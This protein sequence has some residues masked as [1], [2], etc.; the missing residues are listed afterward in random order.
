MSYLLSRSRRRWSLLG[1]VTVR[2]GPLPIPN[3]REVLA[4]LIDVMLVLDEFVLH[5]LFK[6]GAPGTQVWQAID[7]VLHEM[8]AV[9]VILHPHVEGGG[10]GALFLVAADVQVAVGSA[11]GQPVNEP[12]VTMK[13]KDDVLVAREERIVIRFAQS[14]RVLAGRLELHE[15]DDI[16]HADFQVGQMLAE[17]GNG[18]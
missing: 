18:G 6:V 5:L 2:R 7:D 11:V 10:D 1:A 12:R 13:A 17:N 15:I 9:E 8:K 14:V 16:D 3:L 4:V